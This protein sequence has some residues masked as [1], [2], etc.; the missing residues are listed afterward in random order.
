ML[1]SRNIINS[2]L[3]P[4]LKELI[5]EGNTEN[6][7]TVVSNLQINLNQYKDEIKK[8][9]KVNF[10]HLKDE[11]EN[12]EDLINQINSLHSQ[13]NHLKGELEENENSL[14]NVSEIEEYKRLIDRIE[15]I[16]TIMKTIETLKLYDESL[17]EFTRSIDKKEYTKCND[18]LK[19]LISITN[20]K[21]KDNVLETTKKSK[22]GNISEIETNNVINNND[23]DNLMKEINIYKELNQEF[24]MQKE[25]LWYELN[26]E[27]D[28]LL[29]IDIYPK[30]NDNSDNIDLISVQN[31]ITQEY[32]NK[33]TIL[34][35]HKSDQFVFISKLKQFSKKFLQFC[36]ESIISSSE[37][38]IEIIENKIGE[39]TKTLKLL[40]NQTETLPASDL[41]ELK[42]NQIEQILK[43]LNKN[44]FSL[45][46][47]TSE[48]HNNSKKLLISIF[49]DLILKDFV[50]LI[51]E[52]L[53]ISII[54]IENYD[55][56]L[57]N[58]I[59]QKVD[60]FE[61]G[62][63]EL[64]FLDKKLVLSDIF[65]SFKNNVEEL[66]VRKKCKFIMEKSR[67]QMKQRDTLFKLIKIE[68]KQ[69]IDLFKNTDEDLSY[70]LR[71]LAN[72]EQE[73]SFSNNTRKS[74]LSDFNL[75]HMQTCSISHIAQGT[76]DSVYST[77]NEALHLAQSA[78]DIK[79][80]SLLC[81]V[82]RN[83]FDL[84]ANVIPT[85]HRDN[86][87]DLPQ[88]SAIAYNDFMY[89]AFHCLTIT[90]QYKHL[91]LSLKSQNLKNSELNEIIENFSCLDLI[92]KFY[93]IASDLLNRQIEKQ[94][95]LLM[96]FLNEDCNGVMDL[97]EGN[98]FEQFKRALQKCIFQINK[99]SSLW[100]DVL[101][102][103][104]YHRVFGQFFNFICNHLL[105]SCLRLEDIST[106]D[107]SYLEAGF[108]L[109]KQ[110]IYEIFSK[111]QM[112]NENQSDSELNDINVKDESLADLRTNNKMADFNATKYIKQ[113]Q[114]FK[115]LLKILRANLLE[116]EDMWSDSKGPL[117]LYYNSE[118]V[119]QLIRA[120]FMITDK[121]SA[122]LAKIK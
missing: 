76:I 4:N 11:V 119:R 73:S 89:L 59:R 70:L 80:V 29:K 98:N 95:V 6:L 39:N 104:I 7:N 61:K 21:K 48:S 62:L 82:A 15:M 74:S 14:K 101:P 96:Q 20:I 91:F 58:E 97:A 49:S 107:A 3:P 116:I 64:K 118:E 50:K 93:V 94:K 46:V 110:A 120:L 66:Y 47:Y 87:K 24:T 38:N 63:K 23:D 72:F 13:F 25:R 12:S 41:L 34:S 27:W 52:K 99:I 112:N 71:T 5:N 68:E 10:K 45:Y 30:S 67:D 60:S 1:L 115:Y 77:L 69:K 43:F 117:A 2:V 26:L 84:Y 92:P 88:F 8:Q 35:V 9:T 54:P 42:L 106:D 19:N 81:I 102:I 40:K 103:Q 109:I 105:K 121:R 100:Q 55:F 57:E 28:M 122:T 44:F 78:K 53:I 83:L 31:D 108:T 90:H 86:L 113:W 17:K 37:F 18:L 75:L 22:K 56:Q 111:H 79:N 51:Y 65:D 33:L 85:Y 36:D 114:K 16:N 32:L